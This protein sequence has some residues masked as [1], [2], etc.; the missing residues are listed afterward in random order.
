MTGAVRHI[1]SQNI[2]ITVKTSSISAPGWHGG[3]R[4]AGPGEHVRRS[5]QKQK[6]GTEKQTQND[7]ADT[8]GERK[9][10]TN[11]KKRRETRQTDHATTHNTTDG[12]SQQ[13]LA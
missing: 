11:K 6:K 9:R 2:Y 12:N 13:P 3:A 4:G 5:P 7:K 10:D 1:P 8:T